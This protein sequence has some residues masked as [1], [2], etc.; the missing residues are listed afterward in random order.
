MSDE[1]SLTMDELNEI[2]DNRIRQYLLDH[3]SIDLEYLRRYN[4]LNATLVLKGDRYGNPL[5]YAGSCTEELKSIPAYT[6]PF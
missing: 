2:I 1:I 4:T 5:Q 6:S 3:L